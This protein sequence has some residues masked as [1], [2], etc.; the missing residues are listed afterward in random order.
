[1]KKKV[2]T[3]TTSGLSHKEGISTVILDYY[4]YFDK[5]KF[6]LDIVAAGAADEGL[7]SEFLAIDVNVRHIPSRKESTIK[8]IS[9][10]FRL[11]RSRKYDAIY[12]HGSSA[13]MVI[14][15]VIAWLCGCKNR[16]VHSHNTTC[17]HKKAD[18]L[19]RPLFYSMY[20]QALACGDA[21]GEWL[22]GKRKFHV[23][24]NG[25]EF[26]KYCFNQEKRTQ[27]RNRLGLDERT[28]VIGHVG[29]FNNQKNHEYL[30]NVFYSLKNKRDDV[31]LYLMGSGSNF[32]T[33]QNLVKNMEL[34]DSVV[35]MG[36]ICNVHEI[37]QAMDVMVLPSLYEGLPL[38]V[39]EWQIATLPCLVS[40]TVTT[41]CA[42]TDLVRFISLQAGYETW[43]DE[44]IRLSQ[45]ERDEIA[46]KI[47]R[48]T[49][50][51]GY[52]IENNAK[53]LQHFF[54]V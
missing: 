32:D 48:L 44:I 54:E 13:I 23:I 33:V 46:H 39:I 26:G 2:L 45:Y 30:I 31:K 28:L 5:C 47:E 6:E 19:L 14:E 1:M 50:E 38:V 35:F 10:L 21:A 40:D 36:N 34:S 3:I 41:D 53:M 25:R 42:Y 22:F 24:K 9:A 27:V 20:T 8:Y 18:K 52:N 16:V 51:N 7:L 29:N 37:I 12:V 15:L 17:D 11:F 43:A 49:C 4:K